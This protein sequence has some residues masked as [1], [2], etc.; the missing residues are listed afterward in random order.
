MHDVR[1]KNHETHTNKVWSAEI[2]EQENQQL[3]GMKRT[4]GTCS[5]WFLEFGYKGGGGRR[6]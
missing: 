1:K 6:R 2:L 5:S 3:R 4:R